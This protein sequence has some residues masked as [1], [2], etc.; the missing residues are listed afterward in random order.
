[1]AASKPWIFDRSINMRDQSSFGYRPLKPIAPRSLA[2][3]HYGIVRSRRPLTALSEI[4]RNS[5][6][7]SFPQPVREPA[8]ATPAARDPASSV[9][10]ANAVFHSV[11]E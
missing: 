8:S 11:L 4:H 2:K 6:Q 3:D 9:F 10:R 5:D 1:M 7:R